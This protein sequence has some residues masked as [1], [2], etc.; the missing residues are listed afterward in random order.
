M[1]ASFWSDLGFRADGITGRE[2]QGLYFHLSGGSWTANWIPLCQPHNT[3]VLTMY[4]L[5]Q[6]SLWQ[7]LQLF[8]FSN[9]RRITATTSICKE[10]EM[11]GQPQSAGLHACP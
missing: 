11:R 8:L 10:A 7:H 4:F 1:E 9:T 3:G 6:F 5:L 2:R